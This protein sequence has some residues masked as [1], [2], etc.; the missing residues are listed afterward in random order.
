[1]ASVE[2][3]KYRTVSGDGGDGMHMCEGGREIDVCFFATCM[4]WQKG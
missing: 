1:M 4:R 2:G 3:A